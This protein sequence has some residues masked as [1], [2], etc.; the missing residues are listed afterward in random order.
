MNRAAAAVAIDAFLRA[1]GRDAEREPELVGTPERVAAAYIDELLSG[2][3]VDVDALLSANV[4]SGTSDTVVVRNV[5]VTTMCPHHLLPGIGTA[6]VAFRPEAKLVGL[7]AIVQVVDAFAKRLVL[8]EALGESVVGALAQHLSPKWVAC[9][10]E[11]AHGCMVARGE[12]AHG[13]EV[14]TF[15]FRGTEGDRAEAMST[16]RCPS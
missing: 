1:L 7:G 12:E 11:L 4:L 15:S 10:I 9:R 14:E 13:A 2:Y 8:Q 16:L 3:S 5:R 6:T